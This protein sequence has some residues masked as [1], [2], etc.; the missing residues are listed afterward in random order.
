MIELESYTLYKILKNKDTELFSKLS[1]SFFS[2]YNL[3]LFKK[4]ENYYTVYQTLCSLDEFTNL[5]KDIVIDNYFK[6]YVLDP[7]Y[8][9][10]DMDNIPSN[11]NEILIEEQRVVAEWKEAGS[12]E[13]LFL[14]EARNGAI[15]I[16][17]NIDED[18]TK[19]YMEKLPFFQLRKSIEYGGMLFGGNADT[20]VPHRHPHFAAVRV[21]M[22][23]LHFDRYKTAIGEFHCVMAQVA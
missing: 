2:G 11:F 4:L 3:A 9:T 21:H 16:F 18:E 8:V 23:R 10:L 1:A 7:T 19:A 17:K 14:R 5:K 22:P 13:H 15:L 12:L 20:G 6:K